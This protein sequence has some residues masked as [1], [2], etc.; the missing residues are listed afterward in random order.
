MVG[1]G[2]EAGTWPLFR[3]LQLITDSRTMAADAGS[4]VVLPQASL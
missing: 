4:Q 2:G 1:W 3:L